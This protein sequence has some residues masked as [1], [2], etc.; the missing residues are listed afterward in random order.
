VAGDALEHV[1][2][3]QVRVDPVQA[4][5]ADQ[6]V[7]TR[8]SFYTCIGAGKEVV[9][10]PEDERADGPFGG[11]VVDFDAPVVD[12]TGERCPA[13]ER[14]LDGSSERWYLTPFPTT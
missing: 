14:V 3:V 5:A 2:K 8:C 6:A 9:A 4:A 11:V 1:P 12:V 7:E 10:P 13:R